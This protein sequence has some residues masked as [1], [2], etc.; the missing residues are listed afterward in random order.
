MFTLNLPNGLDVNAGTHVDDFLFSV[1]DATLFEAW[2]ETVRGT[3]NIEAVEKV[4]RTGSGYMRNILLEHGM[5][6]LAFEKMHVHSEST[7]RSR[8]QSRN[9]R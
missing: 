3:L 8:R 7:E 1:N 5:K 2:I 6:N 9:A 4:T